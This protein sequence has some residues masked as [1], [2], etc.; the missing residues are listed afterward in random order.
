[1]PT[2][3]PI[4]P[5][6]LIDVARQLAHHHAGAGRP[7]PVWLRRAV[8]SSY[9]ALFHALARQTAEHLVPNACPQHRL[10]LAR[11][12]THAALKEACEWISGRRGNPPQHARA[13]ITTLSGTSIE[14]VAAVLCDLQEA[15]HRADYDH[16]ASFSKAAVLGYI[17][18]ADEA[19]QK[20]SA[21]DQTH[22]ETLFALVALRTAIR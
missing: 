21:A 20:L 11:T 22:R 17:Q 14:D 18:D 3:V 7:R 16:L 5:A 13:L 10:Q 15:R 6:R 4:D 1:M 2:A 9:Y 12:F 8:S 19:I